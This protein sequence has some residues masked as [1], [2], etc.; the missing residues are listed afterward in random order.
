MCVAGYLIGGG[1]PMSLFG[2]DFKVLHPCRG[3]LDT[4]CVIGWDCV[5][6]DFPQRT[7]FHYSA[8]SKKYYL[9]SRQ[10]YVDVEDNRCL[11]TDP[12]TWKPA[13][14]EE[15]DGGGRRRR[16]HRGILAVQWGWWGWWSLQLRVR[17]LLAPLLMR[18]SWRVE[19]R[20]EWDYV[21]VGDVNMQF[22]AG[23]KPPP[24]FKIKVFGGTYHAQD[25]TVFYHD[26]RH[27]AN[28]RV[29]AFLAARRSSGSQ[30]DDSK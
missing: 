4:Q 14:E 10:Q 3:P 28:E 17:R 9:V 2:T 23:A 6:E 5:P 26:I 12:L 13:G 1:L 7:R 11:V 21:V 30:S 19:T 18:E 20:K 8:A 24:F 22:P 27:N 15:G 25:F 29:R 16:Q